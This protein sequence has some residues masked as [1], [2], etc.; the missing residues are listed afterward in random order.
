MSVNKFLVVLIAVLGVV[1]TANAASKNRELSVDGNYIATDGNSAS[2]LNV[3]FAQF[4]TPQFAVVTALTTQR[5]FVY[6][7][8]TIGVGGKYFFMDGFK[9]DLVPFAGIGIGLRLSDT[10][11]ES[12]RGSTQYDFNGGV[13]YFLSDSTTLDAKLRLLTFNDSSPVVTLITVGFSQRF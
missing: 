6:T 9:G 2:L 11:T 3:S 5:N 4:V 10:A 1:S 12:N 8:T 13:A 7:A